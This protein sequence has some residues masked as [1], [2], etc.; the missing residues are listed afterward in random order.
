MLLIVALMFAGCAGVGSMPPSG[1]MPGT[2]V[3][4]VTYPGTNFSGTQYQ[5]TKGDFEIIGPVTAEAES[6]S[7][8][9]ILASGDSGYAK[10][11]E[12]AKAAGADD[13]ICV[14]VDTHYYNILAFYTRV[15]TKLHGVAIKWT[16]K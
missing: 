5:F 9:G 10:L 3:G 8:L 7:I 1:A 11:Y 16:K 13:V 4:D 6:T 2:I 14:K 15:N 12:K